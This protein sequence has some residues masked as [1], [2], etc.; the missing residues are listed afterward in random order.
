MDRFACDF[1]FLRLKIGFYSMGIESVVHESSGRS[2]GLSD[3]AMCSAC[4]MTVVWMQ[5]QLRQ[6][7]TQDRILNYVNEVCMMYSC[8]LLQY[9]RSLPKTRMEN[10]R[11]IA[12]A[13]S[14]I[15][16]IFMIRLENVAVV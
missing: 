12:L 7:Q 14:D 3:P 16:L 11:G 8:A 5:H 10:A 13:I 6:N 15:L 9:D 4:E 2:S 1:F